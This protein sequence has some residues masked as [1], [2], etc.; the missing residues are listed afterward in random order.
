[1]ILGYAIIIL[2]MFVILALIDIRQETKHK[3]YNKG[4][5]TFFGEYS[6]KMI[7]CIFLVTYICYHVS[8]VGGILFLGALIIGLTIIDFIPYI[9]RATIPEPINY[10][11]DTTT[12]K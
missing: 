3:E 4:K 12:D 8:D 5:I 10:S 2:V 11:F 9:R 1:M 7:S 6:T